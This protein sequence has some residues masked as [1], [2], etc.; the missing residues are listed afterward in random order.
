MPTA[1]LEPDDLT[2]TDHAILR[3][4]REGRVTAPYVADE[5]DKSLEYIRSRL[6]RLEEHKHVERVHRGL[7]EL[8]DDPEG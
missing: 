2:E 1:V 8:V 4:L 5:Q 6:V 7:Y 3:M